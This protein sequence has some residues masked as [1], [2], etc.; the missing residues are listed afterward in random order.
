MASLSWCVI[1]GLGVV[2]VVGGCHNPGQLLTI[3]ATADVE[4]F[5]VVDRAGQVLWQIEALAPTRVRGLRYG[6]VPVGFRQ[7]VPAP[8]SAPRPLSD[9]EELITTTLTATRV[10]VHRGQAVGRDGFLGGSWESR[11]RDSKPV[12]SD[13]AT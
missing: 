9:G 6:Q 8:T 3:A 2:M 11:P 10:F 12:E 4:S 5:Q 13:G 1:V 7:V